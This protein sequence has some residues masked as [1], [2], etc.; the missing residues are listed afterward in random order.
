M[1]LLDDVVQVKAVVPAAPDVARSLVL[2]DHDA[3]QPLALAA[4]RRRQPRRR[5]TDDEH[6]NLLVWL[7]LGR[8]RS[9]AGGAQ[10]DSHASLGE[11]LDLEV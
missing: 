6:V 9:P 2:L 11:I 5:A 4:R 1:A 7:S 10:R 3:S 8:P